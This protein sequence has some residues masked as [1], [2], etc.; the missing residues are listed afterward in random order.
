VKAVF[1]GTPASAVPSLE[2]LV[3]S[4]HRIPLVITQPDRPAGRSSEL[5]P[6]PVKA[7]ALR[8]GLPVVQPERIRASGLLEQ[9][10]AAGP[11]ILVVVAYGRI[12]PRPWLEAA[13]HGVVNV[14]FSLLPAYRGAAPV[15]WAIARGETITGVSTIRLSE[16]LDEGDILLQRELTVAR[17]EHA[18]SLLD[19]MARVGAGLLLDTLEGLE[20]GTLVPR[21]QDP[22]AATYAP[23]L[24]REDGEADFSMR[25]HEI[26][27]R[28]RGF[29][30]WPGVWAV[31][32]GRR[33][34]L[35]RGRALD[36]ES[37]E[38]SPGKILAFDGEGFRI[39]CGRGTVLLATEVQPEGR[40][41]L[42]AREAVNGRHAAPGEY[43]VGQP[44]TS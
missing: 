36:D 38:A 33:L 12:L 5:H 40:R 20:A 19:R 2:A 27:G 1:L 24:R 7:A 23:V 25:A 39:A 17:G 37:T 4:G 9:V 29:D 41:T 44:A 15:Q 31:H 28:I 13:P 21:P 22:A 32:R 18:P 42:T 34:R 11:E 3:S 43:L 14:H 16:G 35:V 6:P 10:L 26:E 30:P 8:L